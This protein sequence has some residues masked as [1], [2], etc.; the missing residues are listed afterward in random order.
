MAGEKAVCAIFMALRL[1][2]G[3]MM[4][5]NFDRVQ[6]AIYDMEGI[7]QRIGLLVVASEDG[8]LHLS[9]ERLCAYQELSEMVL[10]KE[11]KNLN[12]AV[13]RLGEGIEGIELHP[14]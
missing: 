2:R 1:K 6:S 3:C 4:D 14:V 10:K 5:E 7:G 8:D 13:A 11:I 9:H 12:E